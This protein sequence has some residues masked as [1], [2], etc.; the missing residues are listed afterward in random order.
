MNIDYKELILDKLQNFYGDVGIY[1]DDLKGH[2]I[3]INE[4]KEYNGAS[5]I[6]LYILIA[7]FQKIKEED[8]DEKTK[9]QYNKSHYVDGSGV[10]QFLTTGL[11]LSLIDTA[12]L[13][14][15][16]SD[17]VATN[18]LIDYLTIPY[19]NR[20]IKNI[21]CENTRLLSHFQ[22][23]EDKPF[24]IITP[25]DY[26]LAWEKLYKNELFNE[27]TTNKIINIIKNGCYHEMIGDGID[28][29]YKNTNTPVVN[30]IATKSGKY[31]YVRADGG[32]V[33]TFLGDYICTIFIHSIKDYNYMNDEYIYSQ[34]KAISKLIFDYFLSLHNN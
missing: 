30:Y 31:M 6:K 29:I 22:C 19:I 25:K 2:T 8:I 16:I 17:N 32:I 5:C 20:I 7:L 24:S 14:M 3:T 13:M 4:K 28:E 21:G 11:K 12:T 10:I 27:E 18:M 34:G 33:S 1:F 9:I 15:I 23:V 26:Y